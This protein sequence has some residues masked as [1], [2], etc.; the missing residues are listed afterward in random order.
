MLSGEDTEIRLT[1]AVVE[2]GVI[3]EVRIERVG[4]AENPNPET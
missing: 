4:H 2:K 1:A 3:R